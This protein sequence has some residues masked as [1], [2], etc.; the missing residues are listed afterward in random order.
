ML[1]TLLSC[2]RAYLGWPSLSTF[3]HPFC[4]Q[5]I[6]FRGHRRPFLLL[7]PLLTS[8]GLMEFLLFTSAFFMEARFFLFISQLLEI[9]LETR[10][11]L[12]VSPALRIRW[13]SRELSQNSL[14]RCRCDHYPLVGGAPGWM[15]I[16]VDANN[17]LYRYSTSK[18][19]S[20]NCELPARNYLLL[21]SHVHSKNLLKTCWEKALTLTNLL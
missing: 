20:S 12:P 15:Y 11:K 1:R 10:Q 4:A 13:N 17:I 2:Q 21:K 3:Y 14:Y 5:Q 18:A 16:V 9:V 6:L 7:Y 19:I 8:R